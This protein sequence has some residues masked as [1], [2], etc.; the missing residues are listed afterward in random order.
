MNTIIFTQPWMPV[1]LPG[2][3]ATSGSYAWVF[4]LAAAMPSLMAIVY[5]ISKLWKKRP[6]RLP[7]MPHQHPPSSTGNNA[8]NSPQANPPSFIQRWMPFHC[9]SNSS[10]EARAHILG[11][12][13]VLKQSHFDPKKASSIETL[14]WYLVL[15]AHGSGKTTAI[16]NC[17]LRFEAI[18]DAQTNPKS[19][20]NSTQICDMWLSKQ[21]IVWDA[22]GQY[23]AHG[24]QNA[25]WHT[26]LQTLYRARKKRPLDAVLVVVGADDLY[27][28]AV[29]EHITENAA[30][31]MHTV[32]HCRNNKQDSVDIAHNIHAQLEMLART[33]QAHIPIFVL[34]SKIDIL[35]GFKAATATLPPQIKKQALGIRPKSLNQEHI[36]W[37]T[38]NQNLEQH[39]SKSLNASSERNA[40]AL[41]FG[42]HLQALQ[43]RLDAWLATL[44]TKSAYPTPLVPEAVFLAS[45]A[46][47][48]A[49]ISTDKSPF[50]S[51]VAKHEAWHPQFE[52]PS[53][54]VSSLF[55]KPQQ[56]DSYL[57]TPSYALHSVPKSP[58]QSL[59]QQP[60]LVPTGL[61]TLPPIP[62]LISGTFL[63]EIF[64][65]IIAA[66]PSAASPWLRGKHPYH[67]KRRNRFWIF[68]CIAIACVGIGLGFEYT[69][70]I[71]SVKKSQ[72][73]RADLGSQAQPHQAYNAQA[74]YET[75]E[76]LLGTSFLSETHPKKSSIVHALQWLDENSKYRPKT[77]TVPGMGLKRLYFQIER[78]TVQTVMQT[79]W[80]IPL[81]M[82]Q[83]RLHHAIK[84]IQ[85]GSSLQDGSILSHMVQAM[86]SHRAIFPLQ[87]FHMPA[88]KPP[89][90]SVNPQLCDNALNQPLLQ[91]LVQQWTQKFIAPWLDDPKMQT[92]LIAS[93]RRHPDLFFQIDPKDMHWARAFLNHQDPY[94]IILAPIVDA[95]ESYD[96][97]SILDRWGI[98]PNKHFDAARNL[99]AL[100]LASMWP[101]LE[102]KLH[103]AEMQRCHWMS[104][105]SDPWTFSEIESKRR[106]Y[107]L[108]ESLWERYALGLQRPVLQ[109][110]KD[111]TQFIQSQITAAPS[112]WANIIHKIAQEIKRP[113]TDQSLPK[114]PNLAVG[115]KD[116]TYHHTSNHWLVL[117]DPQ[118]S[119]AASFWQG[120]HATYN[121]LAPALERFKNAHSQ[122]QQAPLHETLDAA[123]N[124]IL[125]S[126]IAH[127][128]PDE[129][130]KW[131]QTQLLAPIHAAKQVLNQKK[132]AALQ[133]KWCTEVVVPLRKRLGS[134]WHWDSNHHPP[135]FAALSQVFHPDIGEVWQFVHKHIQPMLEIDADNIK[136]K[137]G[138]KNIAPNVLS[139]LQASKEFSSHMFPNKGD[140]PRIEFKIRWRPSRT[141]GTLVAQIDGQRV[142]YRGGPQ[143]WQ[144]M[145]WPQAQGVPG[146]K[147]YAFD[148]DGSHFSIEAKGGFGFARLID[149]AIS[150]TPIHPPGTWALAYRM[151]EDHPPAILEIRFARPLRDLIQETNDAVTP[152]FLG[153]LG[154]HLGVVPDTLWEEAP[155]DQTF[156]CSAA[157]SP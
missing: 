148:A 1:A 157:K 28:E 135:A 112:A 80:Q 106:L 107:A 26:L 6:K 119:A 99:P 103:H 8:Q 63:H 57:S 14:P 121:Q 23:T 34:V 11:K 40:E 91:P 55:A 79:V 100:F 133:E 132:Y 56:Q 90:P 139:F 68:T 44:A 75:Q 50:S 83:E 138:A 22:S 137:P 134:P 71:F 35:P 147:I 69:R 61:L 17:G 129:A 114:T 51:N 128:L 9:L 7:Q 146:A 155:S 156:L 19:N 86:A 113:P 92:Q 116:K 78:W 149:R 67:Q 89:N 123:H 64:S 31:S 81:R 152:K 42:L 141:L 124:A 127:P 142:V 102:E 122:V 125:A 88:A 76:A 111:V 65:K 143:K 62:D 84:N 145:H 131:L 140:L 12:I 85:N 126:F 30:D 53:Q 108:R 70:Q 15:G 101:K 41:A 96:G 105:A 109:T 39:V 93:T 98:D 144:S 21:S 95:A 46:S 48:S 66:Y 77:K 73:I 47:P 32:G 58:Q 72:N 74:T 10:N 29:A 36:L 118:R 151:Q 24:H 27:P 115:Q 13:K 97:I 18:S 60:C 110:T 59:Q 3:F 45:S 117:L 87:P 2:Q 154:P 153:A 136:V 130:S 33:H 43:K 120:I 4:I 49:S 38:E 94:T 52:I 5:G 54:N 25:Q 150:A 37:L 82:E 104:N 16:Q 20:T